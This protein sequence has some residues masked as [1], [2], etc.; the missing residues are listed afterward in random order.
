MYGIDPIFKDPK[1]QE[2]F[3]DKGY[4]KINLLT[5]EK[6]NQLYNSYMRNK[7]AHDTI[8]SRYQA[9]THTNNPELILKINHEIK[10]VV[11][12]EL[13][14]HFQ[15]FV[16]MMC[17]Y[18]TK[19]PGEGSETKLHQ[20]P[21]FVDETKFVSA[22]IWIALHDINHENGNLFF[23][24]GTHRIIS[25]LRVTPNCPTAYDLVKDELDKHLNEVPVKA[26]EAIVINHA[27]VHG[28]T[29]NLSKELRIASV[30]AIRS[31]KSDWIYHYMEPGASNDKIERYSVNLDTFIHLEKDGRPPAHNFIEYTSWH[32]PQISKID[33]NLRMK[34]NKKLHKLSLKRIL[35]KL[36]T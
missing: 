1:L 23:I 9:T 6:T 15:N 34:K 14:R 2:E 22:N 7:A 29:P 10:S 13:D 18:I 16:P 3:D 25:S 24:D 26:G 17:T 35:S 20:D 5:A 31:A 27:T 36:F 8:A 19:L 11:L 21:T 30:M 32:F 28:A 4:V 33:F 12:P